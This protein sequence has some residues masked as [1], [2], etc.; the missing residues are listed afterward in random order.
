[1]K[2]FEVRH[3][4]TWYRARY[5]PRYFGSTKHSRKKWSCPLWSGAA[6]V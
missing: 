2:Y 5:T 6:E 4:Q 1:M 3:R